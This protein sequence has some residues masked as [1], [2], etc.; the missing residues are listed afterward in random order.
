MTL[1]SYKV[2]MTIVEQMNFRKAADL[3]NLTPS[4][5]SHCISGME[6]E[7]GFPLFIRKKN[8]ISLTS[9]AKTL[10]PYVKQLL[11]CDDSI[12]QVVGEIKGMTRGV[13]RLGCFNSVCTSWIPRLVAEFKSQYPGIELELYQGA[14]ADIVEWL[15][16]G[17]VD[18]GFLSVSS[19]G[20]IPIVPLYHDKLM[21][22]VP[23]GFK[24]RNKDYISI[25]ELK[26]YEYVQ[27]S[28]NC[29]AD[30]QMLFEK[31]G[32]EAQSTIHVVDDL[33]IL[34]MVQSG[35]GVCILP[36]M[37][38]S[39]YSAEV[40]IYPIYPEEHRVIGVACYGPSKN[41]PSVQKMYQVIMD[42]FLEK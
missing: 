30:S 31:Y 16:N 35:F 29:D 39:A 41:V 7:L 12:N 13:V 6:E 18:I 23:K 2:F 28:E 25:D 14:Y 26:G 5:V 22:V 34:T 11:V 27:P 15:E 20:N 42:N 33:S 37:T 3:L 10:I 38:I 40:D 21:A 17:T 36:E 19:A 24:T 32:F 4:A 1:L 8:K 9:D